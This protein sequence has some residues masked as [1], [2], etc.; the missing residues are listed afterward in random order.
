MTEIVARMLGTAGYECHAAWQEPE[1]S[2]L[3]D[4]KAKFDVLFFH[5][6]ALEKDQELLRWTLSGAGREMHP[7]C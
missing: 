4:S 3:R 2:R 5:V 1:I 6:T 7:L